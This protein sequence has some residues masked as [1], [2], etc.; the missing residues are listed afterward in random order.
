MS[1][2]GTSLDQAPDWRMAAACLR[3]APDAM[4]P[5]PGNRTASAAAVAVCATCPVR[6][7]CLTEAL[8]EEGGRTKDNRFGIRGGLTPS[9][10]WARRRAGRPPMPDPTPRQHTGGKALAPCGTRAAYERHLRHKEPV[11]DACREAN[12]AAN[13]AKRER[14]RELRALRRQA[15]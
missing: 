13:I 14:Q 3:V 12:N 1:T 5:D 2:R 8:D 4:F 15:A 7:V 10:R 9:Q 6:L 11:D